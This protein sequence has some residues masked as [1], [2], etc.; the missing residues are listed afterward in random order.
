MNEYY[1]QL[2]S[3]NKEKD[4]YFPSQVHG[5]D[6]TS[7]VMLFANVIVNLDRLDDRMKNLILTAA[8][9]HDI[10]RIDDRETKEHG[11][12]GMTKLH[13]LNLLKGFSKKDQRII[14]FAIEQHSLSKEENEEALS[15]IPKR[16]RKDYAMVLSYLKDI[17]ALD[18]FRIANKNILQ[19]FCAKLLLINIT[20]DIFW[21]LT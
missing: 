1:K 16:N 3:I 8:R 9:Y 12:Y 17:D 15:K 20:I 4:L 13:D 18:R 11:L 5:I 19:Q 21:V 7:R 10:G 14:E 6:H 2:D